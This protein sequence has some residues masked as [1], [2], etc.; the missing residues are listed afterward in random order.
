[1]KI[2][3]TL[4]QLRVERGYT[5]NEVAD[6]INISVSLLSQIENA[7]SNPSLQSLEGLL[8]LYAVSF[9]DFFR[10]AE[11]RDFVFV[12]ALETESFK[13]EG[14]GY[15]LTLL[16]S[17]L[18]NNTLE[19]YLLDLETGGSIEVAVIDSDPDGERMIFALSGVCGIRLNGAG[20]FTMSEGDSINYKSRLACTIKNEENAS[21][22]LLITGTPPLFR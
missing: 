19:S 15:S 3:P 22:K 2:G 20:E 4:K 1:M 9:S 10:Q 12:R 7:K 11:Q 17:K 8:N 18:Q 6:K 21:V 5:L 16:A 13:N 14:E